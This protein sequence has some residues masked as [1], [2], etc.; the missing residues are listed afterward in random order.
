MVYAQIKDGVVKNTIVLNDAA[1]SSLFSPGFD[2]FL[3]IDNLSP[4]PRIGDLYNGSIFTLVDDLTPPQVYTSTPVNLTSLSSYY[5]GINVASAVTV[6]L[7]VGYTGQVFVIKDES[8]SASINNISI[9]PNG[10]QTIDSDS[11]VL[12]NSDYGSISLLFNVNKW[13]IT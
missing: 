2:Y 8:G 6:N 12:I 10:S 1:L 4:V 7:P 11:S 5:V 13:I 3:R 9:I